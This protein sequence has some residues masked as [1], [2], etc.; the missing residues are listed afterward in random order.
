ML[1]VKDEEFEA[2]ALFR[3]YDRS[4]LP[5]RRQRNLLGIVTVDDVSTS[6]ERLARFRN[7]A[8]W[9]LDDPYMATP[10]KW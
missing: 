1:S 5:C 8:A 10:A 3:K 9:R 2:A 4:A 6:E 7:S